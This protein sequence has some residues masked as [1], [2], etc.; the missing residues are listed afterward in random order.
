[1]IYIENLSH[2]PRFNLA[3]EEYLLI[4]RTDLEDIFLLWQDEPTVVV[5]RNQNT[6]EEI[7][8]A[9][10][11]ARGVHV[12]RRLSGGG[13][14]YHDEG[15]LNFTFIV[16]DDY[17]GGFDFQ[18]FTRPVIRVLAEMGIQA[19]DQ[20]RNDI[21]IDGKKFSGNAQVRVKNRLLHHGTLLYSTSIDHMVAC[22]HVGEEKFVS[23]GV[24]SVNSR[25]T[26]IT[27]HLPAPMPISSFKQLLRNRI[28]LEDSENP[29]EYVLTE[30]DLQ[31]VEQLKMRK[32]AT[33]AWN[34]GASPPFNVQRS[35]Q[36]DWGKIDVR[37]QV[38][39]G[40]VKDM[41]IYGDFFA[42]RDIMELKPRLLGVPYQQ[43]AF[44][45]VLASI[46][47]QNYIPHLNLQGWMALLF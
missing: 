47:L 7:N 14:V 44:K 13:A 24:K 41:I 8:Q 5:G 21:T 27:D 1:M 22:L 32:Y 28:W 12:V 9:Y 46:P 38:N 37:L 26:N 19:V 33:W 31:A 36:F 10:I 17:R 43:D 29:K 6:L 25:V 40:M 45:S 2:D 16:Q 35:K 3:L 42:S 20:G 4:Q 39:R 15:N 11:E 23:K 34:Y 30:A 18:R